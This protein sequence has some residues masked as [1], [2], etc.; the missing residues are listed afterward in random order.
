MKKIIE[1]FKRNKY[2][3]VLAFICIIL[4]FIFILGAIFDDYAEQRA[5]QVRKPVIYLYPET[6]T[7]I[8]VNLNFEGELTCTYP[9][10]NSGWRVTASPDGTLTDENGKVY[11]Y[12]YWEGESLV[13]WD[14]SKGFC[15]K[16]E[17]TA[18]FLENALAELGLDRRE[19]NEFIIYW[20]PIMQENEYNI[21][22]FQTDMYTDI[23]KL[24]IAPQPDTL[25]RVFMTFKASDEYV[26]IEAQELSAP[27][28]VGFTVVEWGGGEVE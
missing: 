25:I 13:D 12:L 9:A 3:F 21:I 26:E 16:G 20:L 28:R 15:V 27:E 11:N 23:A 6:E 14:M 8:T 5:K 17:D 7:E 19:A 22:S 10:Y 1:F 24:D 18:E 4:A 2:K